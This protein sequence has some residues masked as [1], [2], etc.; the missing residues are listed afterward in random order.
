ME[1]L[2][3]SRGN[4]VHSGPFS[5]AQIL[6]KKTNIVPFTQ[7][8]GNIQHPSQL[9]VRVTYEL[10]LIKKK[11]SSRSMFVFKCC[12][13]QAFD[14]L[15]MGQIVVPVLPAY[16]AR[17]KGLSNSHTFMI[18]LQWLMLSKLC[19][20]RPVIMADSLFSGFF[21]FS[22]SRLIAFSASEKT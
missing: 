1:L 7:Y 21:F 17:H 5:S 18:S 3:L 9:L 11:K 20:L 22:Q 16:I 15:H 2:K 10:R 14:F 19:S 4:G 8:Q 13:V 6:I 12:F